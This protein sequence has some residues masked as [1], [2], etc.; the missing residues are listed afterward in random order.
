MKNLLVIVLVFCGI[1]SISA[2]NYLEKIG[3]ATCECIEKLPKSDSE[4]ERNMAIGVCMI[5]SAAPYKKQLKKYHK[6]DVS[7]FSNTKNMESLGALVGMEMATSCPD[8]LMS[9]V[10][11]SL[12]EDDIEESSDTMS[13]TITKIDKDLFVCFSIKSKDSGKTNKYYW[14]NEIETNMDLKEDYN[15]LVDK[16]VR[17]EFVTQELFDPKINDYRV[18]NII[19]E[20]K[21]M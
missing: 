1:Q 2:Q 8:A 20:I 12:D 21:E 9:L 17:F 16:T 3:N 5:K 4:D 7:D 6:I 15:N 11:D 10:G 13:G 18:F 19:T 14:L